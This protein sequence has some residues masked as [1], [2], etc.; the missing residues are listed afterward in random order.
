MASLVAWASVG[1]RPGLAWPGLC[2]AVRQTASDHRE[3]PSLARRLMRPLLGL[4][5]SLLPLVL[6]FVDGLLP[7]PHPALGEM[8]HLRCLIPEPHVYR[9]R[10]GSLGRGPCSRV[11][12]EDGGYTLHPPILPVPVVLGLGVLSICEVGSGGLA[13]TFLTGSEET[14]QWLVHGGSG[15]CSHD[16]SSPQPHHCT[17]TKEA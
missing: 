5:L 8:A 12:S 3:A 16:V 14:L 2:L 15:Y 10:V 11:L 1:S 6:P 4:S 7:R 17:L 9:W 13:G